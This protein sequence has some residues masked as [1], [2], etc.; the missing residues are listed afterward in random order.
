[1]IQSGDI[2]IT[3]LQRNFFGAFRVIKKGKFDFSDYDFYLITITSYIDLE[4]P[5]INDTQL[6]KP[7]VIK[8]FSHSNTPKPCIE[9]HS[10]EIFKNKFEFLG[11]IPLS[12]SEEKLKLKIGGNDGFY[13]VG[14]DGKDFGSQA[15][16]E[17]RWENEQEEFIKE[18]EEEKLKAQEAYNNRILSPKK[19]MD[20]KQF[21]EI[22]SLFDWQQADE[23]KILKPAIRHLSKLK[24]SDIKQF[25]E[26]LTFKLYCLDTKEH[27]LNIG[28]YSYK[29]NDD[30]FSAD[31]FLYAR[32]KAIAN[33]QGFYERVLIDPT[34]MPKD[35][36]FEGLLSL[37][38]T[39]YELKTKKELD[40]STGC[41]YETFSNKAGWK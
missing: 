34:K 28:Q 11:N 23:D 16:F 20:D 19:M 37:S 2:F 10:Q 30:H 14:T 32:C 40:Y 22:I 39:A 24:V 33:G 3:R 5:K 15:F 8:R 13:L 35:E 27:A 7:L 12:A 31:F 4:Q 41:D 18:I 9:I 17:W 26:N 36:D 21:W 29:N 1:M 25:E 38:E 6:L